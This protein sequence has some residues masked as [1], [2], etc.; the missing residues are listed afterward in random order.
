MTILCSF[1]KAGKGE[2]DEIQAL[3]KELGKTLLAFSCP[4][5]KI[6]GDLS[7]EQLKKIHDLEKKLGIV[8]MALD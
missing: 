3:E 5:M 6:A 1:S 7:E 2:L 8:L 4:E